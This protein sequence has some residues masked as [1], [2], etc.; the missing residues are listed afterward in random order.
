ML[1]VNI[2]VVKRNHYFLK[3]CVPSDI[4]RSCVES[5]SDGI[6]SKVMSEQSL[7]QFHEAPRKIYTVCNIQAFKRNSSLTTQY[8]FST[9][10]CI[11][12]KK[13]ESY[14]CIWSSSKSFQKFAVKRWL[15]TTTDQSYQTVSIHSDKFRLCWLVSWCIATYRCTRWK[16]FLM[17]LDLPLDYV[18][19]VPL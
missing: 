17:H 2:A 12:M 15:H 4:H 19:V 7:F 1:I 14:M 6:T 16:S 13:N 9:W 3:R 11:F 18:H 5:P 10:V 8:L